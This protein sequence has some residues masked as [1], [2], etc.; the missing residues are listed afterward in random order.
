MLFLHTIYDIMAVSM[1][2]IKCML[3]LK[4]HRYS[5]SAIL[6]EPH[7]CIFLIFA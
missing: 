1:L 3:C 2:K 4:N 5:F 6:R 7:N